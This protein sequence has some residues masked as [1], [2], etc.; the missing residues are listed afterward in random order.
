M[1]ARAPLLL[2]VALLLGACAYAWRQHDASNGQATMQMSG[3][4]ERPAYGGKLK[5][6]ALGDSYTIGESVGMNDRWP[7]QLAAKLRQA[8]VD[9]SDPLIIAR[10]GWTTGDLA[11]AMDRADLKSEFD[12]V[13]LMIGVNNQ[14]QGRSEEEYRTQFAQLLKRSIALVKRDPKHVIVLSIPDWTA[15]PFGSHYDV[16]RMS[17][18]VDR[19]NAICREETAK[20]AAAYVDVTP[21]S[22]LVASQPD[23]VAEDGLHPSGKQYAEWVSLIDLVTL[24]SDFKSKR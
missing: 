14:F 4:L 3:P 21:T 7:M 9:M 1:K 22:K 16:K 5:Y 17:A 19:F 15:T 6:L 13:T 24:K 11:A 8:N 18:E 20:T 23:W 10:T 12:L 2:A